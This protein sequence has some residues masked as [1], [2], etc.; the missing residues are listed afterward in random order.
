[1]WGLCFGTSRS[2]YRFRGAANAAPLLLLSKSD[3]LFQPGNVL[4]PAFPEE[5]FPH[6]VHGQH[7]VRGKS[8]VEEAKYGDLTVGQVLL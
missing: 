2:L 4:V 8:V 6:I 1:M 3:Q 5:V 7:L